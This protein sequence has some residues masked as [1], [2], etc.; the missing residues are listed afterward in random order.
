MQ[1]NRWQTMRAA[2]FLNLKGAVHRMTLGARV[3]L[4]DADKVLLI[5]HTYVPGWQFPGGGVDPGET[6][7]SAARRELLEETGYKA[8]GSLEL[9]GI[10][11]NKIATNRDHVALYVG[12]Q[13][14]QQFEFRPNREIAEAAW[15]DKAALPEKI[16]PATS[17]RI[18]EVFDQAPRRDVWGY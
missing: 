8:T 17:Q 16:T 6:I 14:E 3:M 2:L 15:F 13:F 4:I 1:M 5:R 18:D 7:E 12:R 11:H 9:F 10:Y